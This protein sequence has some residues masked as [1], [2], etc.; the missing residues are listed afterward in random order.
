MATQQIGKVSM[1]PKGAWASST[2]YERL[3]IVSHGLDSYVA[4]QA[5]PRNTVPS[6]SPSYWQ[7]IASS[8]G[9]NG[10]A[11]YAYA[12]STSHSSPPASGWKSTPPETAP[13]SYLWSRTTQGLSPSGNLVTYSI[14]KNGLNGLDGQGAVNSVNGAT[15]SVWLTPESAGFNLWYFDEGDTFTGN[16]CPAFGFVGDRDSSQN[17][18]TRMRLTIF[19]PGLVKKGCKLKLTSLVFTNLSTVNGMLS[20]NNGDIYKSVSNYSSLGTHTNS[21]DLIINN[22]NGFLTI[23]GNYV[24]PGFPVSG[25]VTIKGEIIA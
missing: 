3:D 13:G 23:N 2:T 18:N 5:V 12:S 7:K 20:A 24:S 6:N 25:Y 1:T 4:I 10:N 15:G 9:F 17:K 22:S 14:A 19:L 8:V 21:V 11:T 16:M